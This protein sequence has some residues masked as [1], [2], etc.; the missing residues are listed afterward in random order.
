MKN[1]LELP[2][3]AWEYQHPRHEK[4]DGGATFY[5]DEGGGTISV[6]IQRGDGGTF[7]F[8]TDRGGLSEGRFFAL[9]LAKVI[10]LAGIL[11]KHLGISHESRK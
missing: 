1:K 3:W 6:Y 9:E 2:K 7:Y 11:A 8:N 10:E 5:E 4:G